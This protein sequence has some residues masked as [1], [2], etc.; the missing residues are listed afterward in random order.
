MQCAGALLGMADG[1]ERLHYLLELPPDSPGF[2]HD[3]EVE[4]AFA[5]NPL[6]AIVHEAC[7]A[8]GGATRWAA[9]RLLPD[10]A[11]APDALVGEHVFPW[12]FEEIGALAPL[13]EAAEILA[14]HEWPRCTTRPCSPPTRCRRPPRSTRTTCSC[15]A[16]SRRTRRRG[17]PACAYG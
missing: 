2:G 12:M 6:Y 13:R 11:D 17:S 5:R 3:L 15:R 14:A 4:T 1:A 8:D 9:Q 7:W 16:P 10:G